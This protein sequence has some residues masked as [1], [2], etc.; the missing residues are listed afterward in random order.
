LRGV[1]IEVARALAERIG[2]GL[3]FVEYPSPPAVL[4]GI[5]DN[6]WDVGFLAVDP[7]RATLVDFSPPYLQ[8]D[9]TFLVRENSKIRDVAALDEVGTR[10]AVTS[11][12][13]EEI[14]LRQT[15]KRASLQS[16][17]RIPAALELLRGG[18]ADALAAPRPALVPLFAKLQGSR[19][20]DGS[21]H[22]AFGAIAV[23]KGQAERLSYVAEFIEHA[24]SSGVIRQAIER[25][26]AR[27][28]QVAPA[29]GNRVK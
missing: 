18:N 13:V 6:A 8:I 7:S 25:G 15:L 20:L 23:P 10:I 29:A 4:Q 3:T 27:G 16:V 19:V 9:A 5:K 22:T 28:V 2:T 1:A 26:G 14:I 12:S 17:E 24:K 21:F 11:K